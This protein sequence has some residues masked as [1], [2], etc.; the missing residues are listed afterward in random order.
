M[1]SR[2]RIAIVLSIALGA[3]FWL[4]FLRSTDFVAPSYI[5]T[6]DG[7]Q[8]EVSVADT[9]SGRTKG[10]SGTQSLRVGTGKLFIFDTPD[11]YGFWMKDMQYPL[12]I[13]WIDSSWKV[14]DIT[15]NVLPETYPTIFL[16]PAPVQYVLE[17]N[18]G[19]TVT[20]SLEIGSSVTFQR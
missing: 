5:S 2:I 10:L 1:I 3:A 19:D 17:V 6:S 14:V 12:D 15:R 4:L 9:P 13:V 11:T 16:P 8:I 20:K 18:A 7:T